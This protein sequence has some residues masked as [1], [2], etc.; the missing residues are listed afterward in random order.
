MTGG[1]CGAKAKYNHASPQ[2]DNVV[3]V[4]ILS[5]VHRQAFMVS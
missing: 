3:P 5:L 4:A 1:V 2:S